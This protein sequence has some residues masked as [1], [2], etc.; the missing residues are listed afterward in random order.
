MSTIL[1]GGEKNRD[2]TWSGYT[3]VTPAWKKAT[4]PIAWQGEW[5]VKAPAHRGGDIITVADKSGRRQNVI[6][7]GYG[8]ENGAFGAA[9]PTVEGYDSHL[10][11]VEPPPGYGR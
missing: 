6:L 2:G 7:T 8:E 11:D 5:R 3:G 10:C 9:R 4:S 1:L